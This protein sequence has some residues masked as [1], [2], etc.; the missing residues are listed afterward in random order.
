MYP[1][2]S[3]DIYMN[4]RTFFL[5]LALMV[6]FWIL[7]HHNIVPSYLFLPWLVVSSLIILKL[8]NKQLKKDHQKP[9]DI[10]NGLFAKEL[11]Q[12]PK[13]SQPLAEMGFSLVDQFY[14]TGIS[15]SIVNAFLHENNRDLFFFYIIN[16]QIT[17]DCSTTYKDD[18]SLGTCSTIN[19]ALVPKPPKN[20]FC[21]QP[22]NNVTKIY[23]R[24]KYEDN[25]LQ[26]NGYTP[27]EIEVSLIRDLMQK[28]NESYYERTAKIKFLTLK[29]FYWQITGRGSLHI[30][31]LAEQAQ[32]GV[33]TI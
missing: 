18:Y 19:A 12:L 24:H 5:T 29:L 13:Y 15:T 31:S 23:Q 33:V 8:S 30:P 28:S 21:V 2:N 17:F 7:D 3:T 4:T 26:Q 25:F 10:N 32:R 1:L 14:Y 27:I 20:F 11:S 6:P 22:T 9:L 16:A